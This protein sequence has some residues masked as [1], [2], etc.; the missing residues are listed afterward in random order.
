MIKCSGGDPC[1][2]CEKLRL[3]C[4]YD[5]ALSRRGPRPNPDN[6][7]GRR[8]SSNPTAHSLEPIPAN[9]LL[10][11]DGLD[12]EAQILLLTLFFTH[13]NLHLGEIIH[14]A[15][16]LNELQQNRLDPHLIYAICAVS[17]RFS[18]KAEYREQS[19]L[20]GQLYASASR[21]TLL[22]NELPS[23]TAAQILAL[24]YLQE[25]GCG[26]GTKA[27]FFLGT[28]LRMC[29]ALRY[30]SY[31]ERDCSSDH[32][33]PPHPLF[34]DRELGRRLYWQLFIFER[35]HVS[36]STLT[37]NTF[38][39]GLQLPVDDTQV[40]S[41]IPVINVALGSSAS[42][43][44]LTPFAHLIR[45]VDIYGRTMNYIQNVKLQTI[46]PSLFPVSDS[47][48]VKI[49][50]LLEA[51]HN[52]LPVITEIYEFPKVQFM[53][54]L[55]HYSHICLHRD[56]D[57][58]KARSHAFALLSVGEP[59]VNVPFVSFAIFH[60]AMVLLDHEN[61][62][63]KCLAHLKRVKS[64]WRGVE[65]FYDILSRARLDTQTSEWDTS[66]IPYVIENPVDYTIWTPI[67]L[68]GNW[69]DYLTFI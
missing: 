20:S 45:L 46:F 12:Q 68:D 64:L 44:P 53:H 66:S 10:P 1:A 41:P 47:D 54:I 34:T 9:L 13:I 23:F 55:Y 33:D 29:R 40:F 18:P 43:M 2:R 59:V 4:E 6:A 25:L 19:F 28:A 27:W 58:P 42:S 67:P 16:F 38:D 26:R 14:R 36:G 50:T 60:C 11:L 56:I 15:W 32:H 37:T 57:R 22:D 3:S 69:S 63:T 61:S 17:A 65:N 52:D 51:W 31:F 5:I 7:K 39:Q 30:D 35:L 24:L 21:M 48:R 8:R 49:A 62:L